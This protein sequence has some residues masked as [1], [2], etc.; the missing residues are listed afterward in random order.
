MFTKEWEQRYT[1]GPTRTWTEHLQ[2]NKIIE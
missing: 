2:K 1:I